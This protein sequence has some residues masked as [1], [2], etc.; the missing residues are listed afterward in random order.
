MK[1]QNSDTASCSRRNY[2]HRPWGLSSV[3]QNREFIM[4]NEGKKWNLYLSTFHSEQSHHRSHGRT[5]RA[6]EV[7][8]LLLEIKSFVLALCFPRPEMLHEPL[9]WPDALSRPPSCRR[10]FDCLIPIDWSALTF[11][12]L[13][14]SKSVLAIGQSF[15]VPDRLHGLFR[16]H[17]HLLNKVRRTD[18]CRSAENVKAH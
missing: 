18:G 13:N 17:A 14:W 12:K 8:L 3:L 9:V 6:I 7:L 16:I 2:P 5:S 1:C 4:R 10:R 15:A 11:S